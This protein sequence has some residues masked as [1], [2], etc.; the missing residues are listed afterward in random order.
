MKG[1]E[2]FIIHDGKWLLLGKNLKEDKLISKWEFPT[3]NETR[4]LQMKQW[5]SS[6]ILC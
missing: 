4:Q 1:F 6:L 5:I 2:S 3:L